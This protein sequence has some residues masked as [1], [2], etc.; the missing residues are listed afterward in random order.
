MHPS[1]ENEASAK[2]LSSNIEEHAAAIKAETATTADIAPLEIKD[3]D[4]IILLFI[5]ITAKYPKYC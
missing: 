3:L 2:S 1:N 4:F 5:Y